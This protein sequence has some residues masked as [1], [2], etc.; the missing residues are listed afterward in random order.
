MRPL[1]LL[2]VWTALSAGGARAQSPGETQNNARSA[3][4]GVF[5]AVNQVITPKLDSV[6]AA[7]E[8][9]YKQQP[10]DDRLQA[11]IGLLLQ[12][13]RGDECRKYRR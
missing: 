2:V 7:A 12:A 4:S 5:G 8:S 6:L 3:E 11:W 1:F 10:N 13:E 9:A